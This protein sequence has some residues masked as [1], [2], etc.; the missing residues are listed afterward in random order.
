[1][2]SNSALYAPCPPL[3]NVQEMVRSDPFQVPE[4]YIRNEKD[5]AN[6]A[7]LCPQLSS[8]VPI[9]DFSL[10][11]NGNKE[12]LHKL[13]QACKE[14]GFFHMVNHGVATELMKGMK[15]YAQKFF[16][17]PLEEKNKIAIPPND[18]QGY[19]H[20]HSDQ[21]LDWSD[22][23]VLIVHPHHYRK[24]EVWPATPF[25]EA[26]EAYSSEVKRVG[27]ELL[28]FMSLIMGMEKDAFLGLHQELVQPMSVA[29]YPQCY[30]PDK[31][32]GLGPHSDKGTIG[33]LM[34]E[35]DVTGLQIK[36]EGKWVPIKPIPDTLVVNVGDMMEI[37]SNG[38]Y[39]SI[40]HRVVTNESKARISCSTFYLPRHDV[41]IEP[42]DQMVLESPGSLPMYKKVKYGDYL[43]QT[44]HMR[45]E[46][47]AHVIKVAKLNW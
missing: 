5:I 42:L 29:Y 30:L 12:E 1:M 15:D 41:E 9:I 45:F 43:R 3:P 36:H 22:K 20:S 19:G 33:I 16:E 17:L 34:Q 28:R 2:G 32:L 35:D 7:D 26:I 31:V 10:L 44:K 8:E 23:L 24:L 39:K 21:I 37:W 38:K 6:D 14:W 40:E 4:R 13:D 11:S 47:K 27:E 25:K 46:G 18:I